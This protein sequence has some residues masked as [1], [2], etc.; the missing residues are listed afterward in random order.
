MEHHATANI[1]TG[2][3]PSVTP[4]NPPASIYI[5][6]LLALS[7]QVYPA[8]CS[9]FT[10]ISS[11]SQPISST[12]QPV[13]PT[14]NT[15]ED[16][17]P[18]QKRARKEVGNNAQMPAQASTS[19]G[20][21]AMQDRPPSVMFLGVTP[22]PPKPSTSS[23]QPESRQPMEPSANTITMSQTSTTSSGLF[24]I[25]HPGAAFAALQNNFC[26]GGME[27]RT[28]IKCLQEDLIRTRTE[29]DNLLLKLKTEIENKVYIYRRLQL[30]STGQPND[31]SSLS[32]IHLFPA[33]LKFEEDVVLPEDENGMAKTAVEILRNATI[34]SRDSPLSTNPVNISV[35]DKEIVVKSIKIKLGSLVLINQDRV[36]KNF[37]SF[38]YR[39][40]EKT[41]KAKCM[42][43]CT[44]TSFSAGNIVESI[45]RICQK[46]GP[47][48]GRGLQLVQL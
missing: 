30:K 35:N 36:D 40:S 13:Q 9:A 17:P 5:S 1:Q 28:Q 2:A 33:I 46:E 19:T 15:S 22:A 16:P 27:C 47:K 10:P 14:N 41:D 26:M 45:V 12:S 25:I 32:S 43:F 20:T 24:P 31:S 21:E 7:S 39:S 18:P 38:I 29:K 34:R 37:F 44:H 4:G 48:L 11:T 8:T 42:V 23:T 3:K 6:N